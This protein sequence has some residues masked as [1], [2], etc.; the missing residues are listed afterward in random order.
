MLAASIK[1]Y[2]NPLSANSRIRIELKDNASVSV[3]LTS[4]LGEVLN[5]GKTEDG[6]FNLTEVPSGMYYLCISTDA[7][8]I[9]KK[10]LVR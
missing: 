5:A 8:V 9:N 6:W 4:L 1:V 2:P 10:V 7:G 3:E